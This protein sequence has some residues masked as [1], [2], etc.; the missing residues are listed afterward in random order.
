MSIETKRDNLTLNEL[1]PALPT[2]EQSE[3]LNLDKIINSNTDTYNK[4]IAKSRYEQ[5]VDKATLLHTLPLEQ[6]LAIFELTIEEQD[7]YIDLRKT[8]INH[9]EKFVEEGMAT[10]S[11]MILKLERQMLNLSQK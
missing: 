1:I 3:L 5:L 8:T 10:T 7:K 9:H 6:R 4:N 2:G 11:E